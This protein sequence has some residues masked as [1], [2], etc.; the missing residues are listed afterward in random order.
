MVR[1]SRI[2]VRMR[3][4][5]CWSVGPEGDNGACFKPRA[6]SPKNVTNNAATT[7]T[8]TNEATTEV[9]LGFWNLIHQI[10]NNKF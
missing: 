10:R 4:C 9:T 1:L 2:D 3:R 8:I 6:N 5:R 7:C